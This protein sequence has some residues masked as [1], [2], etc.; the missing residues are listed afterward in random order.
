MEAVTS[1]LMKATKGGSF[2]GLSVESGAHGVTSVLAHA[3]AGVRTGQHGA[4][5][6]EAARALLFRA[7]LTHLLG[8]ADGAKR[9]ALDGLRVA[10]DMGPR[11]AKNGTE[12]LLHLTLAVLNVDGHLVKLDQCGRSTRAFDDAI[13][14]KALGLAS[15]RRVDAVRIH[16]RISSMI[17]RMSQCRVVLVAGVQQGLP[18]GVSC[19]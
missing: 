10:S 15:S 1:S 8:D 13:R 5:P 9:F 18:C 6:E 12:A 2:S 19:L 14:L 3:L 11:G 4:A 16:V 7:E 17:H